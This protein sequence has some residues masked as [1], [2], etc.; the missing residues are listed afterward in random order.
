MKTRYILYEGEAGSAFGNRQELGEANLIGPLRC[1]VL[2]LKQNP[3]VHDM[4]WSRDDGR[5]VVVKR[6]SEDEEQI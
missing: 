3:D 6:V 2:F 1:I 4:S 5:T